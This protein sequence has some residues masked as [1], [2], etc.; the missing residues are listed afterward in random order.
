MEAR[1]IR[2]DI[3]YSREEY[4]R[5]LEDSL[6]KYEFLDG[7]L[8]MMAGGT[9]AHND[10]ID[11]LGY[12]LRSAEHDCF[13]KGSENAVSIRELNRYYFPDTTAV[14]ADSVEYEPGGGIARL[15]NPALIVEVLSQKTAEYDRSEKFAAYRRLESFREYILIDSRKCAIESYYRQDRNSWQIGSFYRMDQVLP[16]QTLGIQIPLTKLYEGVALPDVDPED[17]LN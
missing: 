6:H 15:I 7:R 2:T 12:A 11:N 4:F 3:R 17:G 5:V 9:A 14:C 8:L 16:I 1:Q 13:I 10:I